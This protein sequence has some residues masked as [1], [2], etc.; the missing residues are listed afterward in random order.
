MTAPETLGDVTRKEAG[1][2][3]RRC[4]LDVEHRDLEGWR[5]GLGWKGEL[6]RS[7]TLR[8]LW[9]LSGCLVA[10]AA[11]RVAVAAAA[12]AQRQL[13]LGS[14]PA[15]DS[16]EAGDGGSGGRRDRRRAR[17]G[18]TRR[19]RRAGLR[20]GGRRGGPRGYPDETVVHSEQHGSQRDAEE[21]GADWGQAQP[22]S[23]WA[24][25]QPRAAGALGAAA[26]AAGPPHP[27]SPLGSAP[28]PAQAPPAPATTRFSSQTRTSSSPGVYPASEPAPSSRSSPAWSRTPPSAAASI[29][30]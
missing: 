23:P 7:S 30:R 21:V 25:A 10:R 6:P 26:H 11:A 29:S 9:R 24:L 15:G 18:G 12:A 17:A 8:G 2:I 22:T 16:Q 14:G 27:R 28:R 4:I 5:R 3:R 1:P 20:A 19:G 13:E